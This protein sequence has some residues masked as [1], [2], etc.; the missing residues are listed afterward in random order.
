MDKKLFVQMN[1]ISKTIKKTTILHDIHMNVSSGH[2][3][4]LC[5]GNGAGK[6]TLLRL[7]AGVQQPSEG[8]LLV[9]G[10]QSKTSKK[11]YAKQIGY[12]PDDYVFTNRLTG[13]ESL[14][15]WAKLRGLPKERAVQMLERVGLSQAANEAVQNYS[16]GMRQR[17]MLAQALLSNPPLLLLDEPTNGLDPYWVDNLIELVHEFSQAGTTIVL[18]THNLSFTEA[19]C[20][21]IVFLRTGKIVF[22]STPTEFRQHIDEEGY[23]D[24]FS[25]EGRWMQ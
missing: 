5:G 13:K 11:A 4:A 15:F 1:N 21:Q 9:G 14:V 25:A 2:V 23:R 7:L 19:I 16:K 17:L 8:T 3:V 12:M 6:S 18:S 10:L 24:A 20:N 22:K